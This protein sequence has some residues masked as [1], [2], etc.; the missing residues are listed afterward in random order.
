MPRPAASDPV[1]PPP[2][3]SGGRGGLQ[4]SLGQDAVD[5]LGQVAGLVATDLHALTRVLGRAAD[6]E[7]LVVE[8][9]RGPV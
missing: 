3:R 2:Y 5:L 4:G 6:K 8:E 1:P 9:V 7:V